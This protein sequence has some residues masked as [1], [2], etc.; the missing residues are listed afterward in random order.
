MKKVL[1]ETLV[2]QSLIASYYKPPVSSYI[3]IVS[4]NALFYIDPKD[5]MQEFDTTSTTPFCWLA[6]SPEAQKFRDL[7][8]YEKYPEVRLLY[9][10][11]ENGFGPI[12]FYHHHTNQKEKK[13]VLLTMDTPRLEKMKIVFRD[14]RR[15]QIC[16]FRR[17]STFA[18]WH[19]QF[20]GFD[21][22]L[23]DLRL[24]KD[25][26]EFYESGKMYANAVAR[27]SLVYWNH[28][29][30]QSNEIFAQLRPSELFLEL[31]YVYW[32]LF[33]NQGKKKE[34]LP[35][36][37]REYR[38]K[39]YKMPAFDFLLLMY[40]EDKENE[41]SYFSH[42]YVMTTF[43]QNNENLKDVIRDLRLFFSTKK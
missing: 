5:F 23:F 8:I 16:R 17:V 36:I 10:G 4:D 24:L 37:F 27:A 42:Q 33:I 38:T 31:T 12:F 28:C 6:T 32:R 9:Q 39:N 7:F 25:E 19:R 41:S 29:M 43:Q 22:R 18:I 13:Y 11:K 3:E 1:P 20:A 15:L 2:Y 40:L 30:S 26:R 14:E 21:Q 35:P 34:E